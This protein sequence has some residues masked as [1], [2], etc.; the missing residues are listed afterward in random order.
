MF[1][2]YSSEKS[3]DDISKQIRGLIVIVLG[4]VRK[5]CGGGEGV[6][7]WRIPVLAV[8][9]SW[10]ASVKYYS[11]HIPLNARKT[12]GSQKF[13]GAVFMQL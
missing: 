1:L 4:S 8:T 5:N 12:G 3:K 11:C 2:E 9:T 6:L 13:I 7:M 10:L